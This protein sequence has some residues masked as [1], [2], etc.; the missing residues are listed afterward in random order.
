MLTKKPNRGFGT[1]AKVAFIIE[2]VVFGG[3]YAV[4]HRMNVSQGKK[5]ATI[6]EYFCSNPVFR[7]FSANGSRLSVTFGFDDFVQDIMG[8]DI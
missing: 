4:W 7:L 8:K 1:I 5:S 3:T 2:L 6:G